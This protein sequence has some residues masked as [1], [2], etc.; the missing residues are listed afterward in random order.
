[1]WIKNKPGAI[2]TIDDDEKKGQEENVREISDGFSAIINYLSIA[3]LLGYG[4]V[5][6]DAFVDCGMH[7]VF[8][9]IVAYTIERMEEFT[10]DH[11]LEKKLEISSTN[12]YLKYIPFVLSGAKANHYRGDNGLPK[13]N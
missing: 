10:T 11:G 2:Q 1:M 7:L 9:G 8:H 6:M 5:A 12:T 13:M 3:T 4:H